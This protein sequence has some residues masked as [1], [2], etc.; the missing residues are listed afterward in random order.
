MQL[1]ATFSEMKGMVVNGLFVTLVA[2]GIIGHVLFLCPKMTKNLNYPSPAP[3][4][5][6]ISLK[7]KQDLSSET[8]VD[9]PPK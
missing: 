5:C 2:L 1:G 3:Q 4:M 9:L 6:V 8:E 7:G